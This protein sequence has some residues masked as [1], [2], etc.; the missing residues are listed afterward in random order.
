MGVL[1]SLFTGVSGLSAQGEALSVIGDNIANANTTGFKASRAEFQDIIAKNLK[2]ILGGNQIGRGVK[3]GAVNP[4][5]LQG[6]VDSTENATDLAISGDGF[7]VLRG[8]DGQSFTRDGSLH[9]DK[10][11]F[12]VTND[13]QRVQG[14]ISDD[15]G[16]ATSF[17]GDIRLP[18]AITPARATKKVEMTLNLDSRAGISLPFDPAKP[19][20]TSH[21]STGVE[22]FDSQGNKHLLTV[23]FYKTADRQWEWHAMA[24]GKEVIGGQEGKMSE[25]SAGKLTF[26][27]DGKLETQVETKK[28]Y[29]FAG[30][31][32]PN[33][34][35]EFTF[36]DAIITNK[37]KGL[38]GT[39][40]YGKESDMLAWKQDGTAAGT[41]TNM[42]FSD[43]GMLS[44]LYSNGETKDLAQL[45]LSKFDAP[46]R[47]YKVGNNRFKE[48]RESGTPAIGNP[49]MGGRG[50]IYAKSLER[51][52]VDLAMEFVNLIQNQ[53][54][55]Q[56][57]AKTITTTDELLA[58]VIQLK[59]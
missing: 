17:M 32:L 49:N 28:N 36:G 30:G 43:T 35:I 3:I 19:N 59:R 14:Y 6:N 2:G 8:S 13:M 41:I 16:K 25:V 1:T 54:G 11:G 4:I 53:R 22:V 47:L 40:Q 57:N 34:Q 29:N 23:F 44:A 31:A 50:K 45:V 37:G 15:N 55:F 18:K 39:V 52:T 5:L 20:D 10:D 38:A 46:E 9:F 26:T 58:E 51:S 33:Q 24:D 21:Y 56:A 42:S 12:L 27:V 7:F 48:S